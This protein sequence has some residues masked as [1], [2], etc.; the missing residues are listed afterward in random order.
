VIRS[1]GI[2]LG[3]SAVSIAER[4]GDD[5]TYKRIQHDGK[6]AAVFQDILGSILPATVGITGRKFRSLL[7]L[8]TV[9]EPEAVELAYGHVRQSLP[10]IDCIVSAGG[11]TF[12]V[13]VLGKNGKIRKV[14]AGNKCASGTGEFFMQQL[15]RMELSLD[16]IADLVSGAEPYL[17]A[18]RCSVFC[19]S[20]CT[21]ALNKGAGKGSIAAGLCKMMAG[22][23]IELLKMAKAQRIAVVGGVSNN[24]LVIDYI[25]EVY[26]ETFVPEGADCFEALGALLWAEQKKIFLEPQANIIKKAFGSF[27]SLPNLQCGLGKVSFKSA[28]RE[29]IVAGEYIL[30]LDVGSTTTKA[31]LLRRDTLAIT[32]SCYL[33]TNGDPV[34][35]SRECY[36]EILAQIPSPGEIKI[37]GL[38]V[39]G[40]GRQIAGLHALTNGVINEI[41]AHAAAAV[42]F[43]PE[44][45]TIFEIGGQ[46]A[47]YT[48]ITNRVASDYAMNEACSAGTGSFL[49]EACSESLGIGTLEIADIAFTASSP[50]DF[51]DQCAAFIGSDIK[52]AVQEQTARPDV[53]AGLVYSICQNYLNRVKG[54]RPVGKK[55]FMQGGVCYNRAVPVAMANLCGQKIIVPPEPGLMGAFGAALEIHRKIEQRLLEK[56]SFDLPELVDRPVEYREPFVCGGGKD[57]CD[58]KCSIARIAINSQIYPFGGACD[59]YYSQRRKGAPV[60]TSLDLVKTREEMV[61]NTYIP[62]PVKTAEITVGIP[63]SLFSNTFYPLYSHF[64]ANLGVKTVLGSNADSIGMDSAGAPFCFP[65]II[66]HGLV[67]DLINRNVNFIFIPHV[68]S[69]ALQTDEDATTCTCPFVQGEPYCMK[70]AFHED[71]EPRL[72]TEVLNFDNLAELTGAFTKIGIRLGRTRKESIAAFEPAWN[73]MQKMVHEM[74]EL[75]RR[76]L[77]DLKPEETAIVMFGR[78]YNAFTKLGNMGIPHKFTSRGYKVIPYDFLPLEEINSAEFSKMYWTSGQGI[79]RAGRFITDTPN[80]FGEIG[81][82]S[83][84]ERV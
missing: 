14:R 29:E 43:D 45:E 57:G 6:V 62:L 2:C 48:F 77:A 33:R 49:E 18:A 79:L 54:N 65:M 24:S 42:H 13:Y 84:R 56:Q 72:L 53:V 9:S 27:S 8:E 63:A 21:H 35:A 23:V 76:F 81:R 11:E 36:R 68:K 80:L 51:N 58:R 47:K 41:V 55:I 50:L 7:D 73:V 34:G 59:M 40:S 38:G 10:D 26:P 70:A 19:K 25:R 64:F 67:K 31:I 44:V 3:A 12:L 37:A 30:G 4:C 78:P 17:M 83:C 52:T 39:T 71:L 1:F 82:A 46:D 66:G 15:Q 16:A 69:S 22:K 20:D 74:K 75:G 5:I 61:F 32:A 28:A 60:N